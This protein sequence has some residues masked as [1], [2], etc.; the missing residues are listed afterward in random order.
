MIGAHSNSLNDA[1]D[2]MNAKKP[3]M[4]VRL[5]ERHPDYVA[6]VEA[7]GAAVAKAGPLDA[8]TVQL[9]QLAAAAA[10][11]SEGGVHSLVRRAVDAGARPE[12]IVHTLLALTSTIGFPNVTAALSWAEDLLDQRK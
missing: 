11:R 5:K 1:G 12:E 9:V 4:Y 8:K 6:A 7:L 2:T 3:G 10:E